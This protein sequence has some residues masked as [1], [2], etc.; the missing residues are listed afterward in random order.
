[1]NA[2]NRVNVRLAWWNYLV[3]TL[4]L[5]TLPCLPAFAG[6][7]RVALDDCPTA[8]QAVLRRVA[9]GGRVIEVQRETNDGD[10]VYEAELEAG[11]RRLIVLVHQ[12]DKLNSK[13]VVRQRRD[14]A[15]EDEDDEE[16]SEE[17]VTLSQLPRAVRATLRRESRGGEI[18]ELERE[19]EH[20]RVIYEAEVEFETGG[21]ELLYEIEI[22]ENGTLLSK[23]LEKEEDE[24]EDS[25]DDED[26]EDDEDD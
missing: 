9:N 4:G 22:A 3:L 7:K 13:V 23:V 2:S 1:M 8:V 12:H 24:D 6:E 14:G 20:G 25:D 10:V 18:E 15:A 5:F 26:D 19:V 11:G 16:E 17:R 21:R